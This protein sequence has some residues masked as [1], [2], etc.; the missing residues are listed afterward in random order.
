[1]I[2]SA[3]RTVWAAHRLIVPPMYSSSSRTGVMITYRMISWR[4][5]LPPMNTEQPPI[6]PSAYSLY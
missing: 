2:H 3:G 6:V 1:M 5:T 4:Y